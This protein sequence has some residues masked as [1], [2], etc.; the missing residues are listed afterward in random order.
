M[1]MKNILFRWYWLFLPVRFLDQK[2]SFF[3]SLPL[4]LSLFLSLSLSLFFHLHL[5]ISLSHLA[6]L[7]PFLSFSLPLPLFL[8]EGADGIV[9]ENLAHRFCQEMQLPEAR[10]FYG[11]QIAME[12]VHQV[13]T[14]CFK[15][16]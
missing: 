8:S 10:C 13:R 7:S 11:F 1:T 15:A 12:T 2:Y 9:M 14:I 4:S 3:L 6:S 16:A 5:S